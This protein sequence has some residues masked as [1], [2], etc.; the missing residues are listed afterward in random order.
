MIQSCIITCQKCG[1]TFKFDSFERSGISTTEDIVASGQI[2]HCPKCGESLSLKS[3]REKGLVA[4]DYRGF[5]IV[6]GIAVFVIML[7]LLFLELNRSP[8]SPY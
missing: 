5:W 2:I 7:I 4:Y 6:I 3:L 1:H 8:V